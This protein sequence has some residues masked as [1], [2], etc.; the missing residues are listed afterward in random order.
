MQRRWFWRCLV[1]LACLLSP[2]ALRAAVIEQVLVVIDG[3][4]YTLTDFKT[5]A[6][7]QM[8]RD[9]PAGDLNALG[10]EDQE[11]IEQFITDK[12]LAAEVKQAGI[13]VTDEEI[14]NY[15]AQ[16][17]EKNRINEDQLRQALANDGI[18]WEKYRASIRTEMEKNDLLEMQVRKRVNVTSE[19]VERY[20]NLNQKKYV[21][22]QKVRLRHILI[23]IPE[24]DKDAEKPALQKAT[25]IRG[26]IAAGEDFARL[27]ETYSDGAGSSEGGDIGWVSHG[28]L[29]KEI[30]RV[31]FGKLNLG[32]VSEPIRTSAGLH[33]IKLEGR[34]G[35]KQL[36]F[37]DVREK[38][39][40]EVISKAVEERIQKWLKGDL[41][42]KHRVDVKLAGVVF[43]PE[44]TKEA[45]MDTLVASGRRRGED[46]GFWDFINPFKKTP[47]DDV[48]ETG[49]PNPL[50]GQKVISLFGTPLFR[51]ESADD[52][53]EVD[54]V[55][56]P[57]ENPQPPAEKP[58]ESP[59]FWG[60]LNP[61]SK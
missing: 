25:E 6:R 51:S 47:V 59:G 31:A 38:V 24:G 20:Y 5:Y 7:R 34:E 58:K 54:E 18:A 11:V 8:S 2:P 28:S 55:L 50:A 43:R 12:L 49:K 26:R 48:D 46:S 61:F 10:K 36:A 4:P 3:E 19:D 57:V 23:A 27:A 52:A 53:D 39:R 15:I 22:E 1:V 45:T 41:R 35:G 29:L 13:K 30:D 21:S 17:K 16:V 40:E 56:A 60:K 33:I 37:A 14:N 44:D 32:D 9:F 42:R